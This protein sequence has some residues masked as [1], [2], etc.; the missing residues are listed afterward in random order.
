MILGLI[1]TIGVGIALCVIG[2][3]NMTGDVSALHSYH[4]KRVTEADRKPFGRLVGIANILMG[5]AIIVYGILMFLCEKT[6]NDAL[7]TFGTAGMLVF[8]GIGLGISF[9]AMKKYN[10]GIF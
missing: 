10:K 7:M 2:G 3:I 4:R 6:G 5:V 1:V 9:Y 8:L